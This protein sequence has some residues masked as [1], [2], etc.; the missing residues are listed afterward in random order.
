MALRNRGGRWHYRFKLD[1]KEYSGTTDLAAT[2]QNLREA[3]QIESE[4]LKA[5]REG[6]RPSLRVVVRQ[7]SDAIRD[8]LQWAE[9]EYREHP[10]S[11]RRLKT[12]F[13]SATEFFGRD[14]VS[15]IDDGRV[16]A[17][18]VWRIRA[19]QVRDITLRHDLHA[20]SKFFGYAIRMHWANENPV[21]RVEIPSDENAVR[22]HVLNQ[23]EERLYF[24]R[25][26]MMPDLHDVGRL[27]LNLGMR[28]DEVV[29][30]RKDDVDLERGQLHI[31]RGKT[32]AARRT[33]DL[34]TESRLILTQ[35]LA[36]GQIHMRRG[37]AKVAKRAADLATESRQILAQRLASSSQWLFPSKR[38]PGQHIARVNSAHDRLCAAAAEKDGVM[39][40]FVLYDLRHT[41][42]TRLAQAGVDLATVAAILARRCRT[43]NGPCRDRRPRWRGESSQGR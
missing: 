18:K 10:S 6:R 22:I 37:K 42:A 11:Y 39:L 33:L 29:S 28:P 15:L 8:F 21:R 1:G 19:H 7:F 25:A 26:A 16:E 24:S 2:K 23:A 20:L 36:G 5:L 13:A 9:V 38:N 12:S 17:Y 3:Q 32:K 40:T 35:R 27:I 30:L 34:T 4:H 31:R 41:F 43:H 14:A